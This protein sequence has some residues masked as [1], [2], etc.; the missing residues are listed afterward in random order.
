VVADHELGRDPADVLDVPRP[1]PGVHTIWNAGRP[2]A[3]FTVRTTPPDET[4]SHGLVRTFAIHQWQTRRS[5]RCNQI[6]PAPVM[7]VRPEDKEKRLT[8]YFSG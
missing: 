2:D 5:Q 1:A 7:K 8:R 4:T 6:D 3:I